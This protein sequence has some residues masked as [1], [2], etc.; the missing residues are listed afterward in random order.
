[1]GCAACV[2]NCPTE[3]LE[4]Y[5]R[6]EFRHFRYSHYQCIGCG[7]CVNVCPENAATLNHAIS[8]KNFFQMLS[9]YVIRNVE[10][11]TCEKCG[12]T[13]APKSQLVKLEGILSDNN[14]EMTLLNY[15]DRCKKNMMRKS[16]LFIAEG[17]PIGAEKR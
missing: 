12:V 16:N 6:D 4:F 7:S 1:V 15:C 10:L 9:K 2:E 11:E 14:V 5:D 3:T 17:E 8:V 13:I